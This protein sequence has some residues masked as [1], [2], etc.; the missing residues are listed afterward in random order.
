MLQFDDHE[1]NINEQEAA[2]IALVRARA[3]AC[4]LARLV[5]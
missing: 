2:L 1:T 3:Y 4:D 5:S